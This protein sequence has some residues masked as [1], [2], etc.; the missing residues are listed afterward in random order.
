MDSAEF[1]DKVYMAFMQR[2][3]AGEIPLDVNGFVIGLFPSGYHRAFIGESAVVHD[4]PESKY[5]GDRNQCVDKLLEE[6]RTA[7]LAALD[8]EIL[9]HLKDTG[10]FVFSEG[11]SVEY[12]KNG[13]KYYVFDPCL[14]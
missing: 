5:S 9:R 6:P 1:G 7:G 14:F 11:I 12:Y 2:S 4:L 13:R 10:T 3:I 8:D